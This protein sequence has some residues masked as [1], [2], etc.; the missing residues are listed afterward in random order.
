MS[1]HQNKDLDYTPPEPG[2]TVHAVSYEIENGSAM[3]P[4]SETVAPTLLPGHSITIE[5]KKGRGKGGRSVC[6]ESFADVKEFP[7]DPS[8]TTA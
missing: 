5:V 2:A 4:L 1:G 7:V 6:H 8:E 3:N